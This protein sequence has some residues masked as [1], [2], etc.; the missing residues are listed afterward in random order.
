MKL[1][2]V[3]LDSVMSWVDELVVCIVFMFC[4]MVVF[5]LMNRMV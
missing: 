4:M 1:V 3:L 5:E 2:D